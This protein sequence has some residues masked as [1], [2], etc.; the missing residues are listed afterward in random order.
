MS[1]HPF[2]PFL[3]LN[4]HLPREPHRFPSR[5]QQAACT[6]TPEQIVLINDELLYYLCIPHAY[7]L[8]ALPGAWLPPT[9]T[10]PSSPPAATSLQPHP[11]TYKTR[12]FHYPSEEN[13]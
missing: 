7:E 13:T 1:S 3:T 2:H 12:S 6:R 8:S 11:H 4:H 5:C 10:A 9:P